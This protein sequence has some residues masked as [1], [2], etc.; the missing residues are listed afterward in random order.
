MCCVVKSPLFHNL[1]NPHQSAHRRH[2]ST[3]TSLLYINWYRFTKTFLSLSPWPLLP[4]I[5]STMTFTHSAFILVRHQCSVLDWF[6][7]Y[8]LSSALFVVS[9]PTLTFTPPK[10]LPQ[11]ASPHLWNQLPASLRIPHPIL[12]FIPLS[13]TIVWTCRF[14]LLNSKLCYHLPSLFHCFTLSSKLKNYLFR[15]SYPPP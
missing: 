13:A 1:L 9:V 4:L 8:L 2:H 14:N 12:L 5:P 6:K 11:H 3:E 15:K 10:R 7:S